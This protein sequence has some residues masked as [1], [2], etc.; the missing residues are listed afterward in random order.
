MSARRAKSKRYEIAI[1]ELDRR[2][3]GAWN[4]RAEAGWRIAWLVEFNKNSSR[5]SITNP[6]GIMELAPFCRVYWERELA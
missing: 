1:D 6:D 5:V 2:D 3:S 4:A